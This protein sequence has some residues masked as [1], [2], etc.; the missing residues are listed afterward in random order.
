MRGILIIVFISGMLSGCGLLKNTQAPKESTHRNKGTGVRVVEVPKDSIVYVPKVIIKEKDTTITVE[1]KNL[2]LKTT[3]RNRRVNK[4]KA[5][6]KPKKEVTQYE[7]TEIKDEKV[8]DSKSEGLPIKPA[9]F[10]YLFLGIGFLIV[11]NTFNQ[12]KKLKN[13]H[14]YGCNI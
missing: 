14:S 10:I 5:I 12:K 4:I 8:K 2:I 13:P 1:N 6:Q 11:V 7:K 9:Y 3:Y